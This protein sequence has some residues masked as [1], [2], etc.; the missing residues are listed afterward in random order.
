[1]SGGRGFEIVVIGGGLASARAVKSYREAG[2]DGRILL[3][4]RD[5]SLPYHRPPLSKG[6]L[7]GEAEAADTLVEPES[8]Y[9]ERDVEVLLETTVRRVEPG[10]HAVETDKGTH[11][12]RRLLIASGA[13]PRR[14]EVPGSDLD[15]VL[16][17][18]TLDDSTQ[19]RAAAQDGRD[20]VVVGGGF[21]GMEVAASLRRLD[22]GVTLVHREAGIF[23][24]LRLAELEGDLAA[25]FA[26]HG[27]S[28]RLPDEVDAF[29]GRG[30]VDSVE[31]KGGETLA[32]R[33]VVVGIG[34]APVTDFL[35]GS[36]IEVDNGVVVDERFRTSAPD[37]FAV[38]D[39]ASFHD[40][41]YGRR[42]IEHWS[43]A[44]YQGTEVGKVLA[45]ADGGYSTVS[46]F[47][48]EIFGVVLKVFGDLGPH[49]DHYVRGS[50]ADR[51]LVAFYLRDGEL[52]ATLAI[53]QEEDVENRLEDLLARR[54][55][56]VA[57]ERLADAGATL[58]EIFP[59]ATA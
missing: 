41:L 30:R 8:F 21:I 43:N 26:D 11:R 54:A 17:L 15:G 18:R 59:P 22:R 38:G 47:F 12:Y 14:L 36:G 9:A 19:I 56:P 53:G 16:T 5:S 10:A 45:G 7:R 55:R 50:L 39:V 28:L 2:G 48:T 49:D 31:T 44:N 13:W 27:V 33:F 6:Y 58:D 46:T 42:R 29:R 20:A 51:N 34:V 32:A 1:M 25:L 40:P 23:Q 35:E 4:S 57:P 37:V 24:H 3:V 52:R